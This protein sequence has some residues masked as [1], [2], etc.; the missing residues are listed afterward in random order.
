MPQFLLGYFLFLKRELKHVRFILIVVGY[1]IGEWMLNGFQ[2]VKEVDRKCR[3]LLQV[4]ANTVFGVIAIYFFLS[5]F[6]G[7]GDD[8]ELYN[9][10]R[11]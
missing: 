6:K 8:S 1:F 4:I 10:R 9:S 5:I 7:C 11:V 2:D 3:S